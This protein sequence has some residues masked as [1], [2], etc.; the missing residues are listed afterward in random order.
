M[1]SWLNEDRLPR[2]YINVLELTHRS[3]P[4]TPDNTRV[5]PDTLPFPN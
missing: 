4:F 2:C 1:L 5:L 3:F